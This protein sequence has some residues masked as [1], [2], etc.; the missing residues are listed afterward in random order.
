MTLDPDPRMTAFNALTPAERE[1]A[2]RR[3][4]AGGA[5][6]YQIAAATGLSIEAVLRMVDAVPEPENARC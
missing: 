6:A 5:G 3:M 4:W 1:A 2:I